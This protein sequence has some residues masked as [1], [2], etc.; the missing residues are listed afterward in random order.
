MARIKSDVMKETGKDDWSQQ[1]RDEGTC[2]QY[3]RNQIIDHDTAHGDQQNYVALLV[4]ISFLF[5]LRLEPA[6]V[7]K[8]GK[9]GEVQE[10]NESR[11]QSWIVCNRHVMVVAIKKDIAALEIWIVFQL[12][13]TPIGGTE[14]RID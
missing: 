1:R 13:D 8:E 12:F 4:S 7:H 5:P 14:P 9:A 2:K 6:E 10:S 3:N 11:R